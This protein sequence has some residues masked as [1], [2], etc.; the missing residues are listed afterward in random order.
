VIL[1][2]LLSVP[3]FHLPPGVAYPTVAFIY[4]IL[5]YSAYRVGRAKTDELFTVF[6]SEATGGTGLAG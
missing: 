1:A 2:T 6:R 4:G 5:A 3:L